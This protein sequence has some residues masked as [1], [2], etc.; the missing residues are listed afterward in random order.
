MKHPELWIFLLL[1]G[2]AL[3]GLIFMY[4]RDSSYLKKRTKET[5]SE[6][7]KEEIEE[8][9]AEAKRKHEK[10]EATLKYFEK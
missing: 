8:E 3:G 10:F 6:P 1:A 2:L 9:I 5:L 4:L 7:L